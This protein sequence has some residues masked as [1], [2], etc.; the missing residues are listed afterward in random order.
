[1][2]FVKPRLERGELRAIVAG[3]LGQKRRECPVDEVHDARFARTGRVVARNDLRGDGFDVRR[4]N[5]A[6]QRGISVGLS[7]SRD[8]D[9]SFSHEWNSRFSE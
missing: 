5:R 1:M 4:F 2:P 9:Q 3:E 7:Y 8:F 6:E